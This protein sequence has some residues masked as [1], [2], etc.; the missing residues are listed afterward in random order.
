MQ[1]RVAG[2]ATWTDN[3]TLQPVNRDAAV[4]ATV[5]PGVTINSASGLL[6]GNLDYSLNAIA[7][8]KTQ[9]SSRF[10][11]A[12]S[13]NGVAELIDRRV[14]VDLRASISQQ[15]ASAFGTQTVSPVLANENRREV[16]NLS[17]SPYARGP[18]AGW[19][20]YEAR[21]N[22]SRTQAGGSNLG[23]GN[24]TGGLLRLNGVASGSLN[25]YA[26]ISEQR[27]SFA[28]T[29]GN[30]NGL[31]SVGLTY[32]PDVELQLGT[33]V[34]R[35]RSDFLGGAQRT[36]AS[37]GVNAQ[38]SPT[39][40]TQIAADV[41]RHDY[42]TA[43]NLSFQHR[44]A[45]SVWQ[46]VDATNVTL[47]NSGAP[48]GVRSN[49]DQY[50]LLFASL[51][52]DPIKR[53]VLVRSYLQS[54]GIAPDAAVS[55]GFLSAGPSRLHN[56]QATV[57]LQGPRSSITL[58]LGRTVTSRLGSNGAS[59]GDLALSPQV[60]QRSYSL[61]AGHQLSPTSSLS[62]TASRLASAGLGLG[63]STQL[64]SWALNWNTKLGQRLSAQLG[65]RHSRFES[66]SGYAENAV[67]SSLTQQF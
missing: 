61:S 34:G 49:Y 48:G 46:L 1:T 37:S 3:L 19:A 14:F 64:T 35:E 51:E 45:R 21:V 60:S 23:A 62:V 63:Q 44:F 33:N 26:Q 31:Q 28:G 13:A 32:R 59:S 47:G 27:S 22:A 40:R 5:S 9:Q 54:L 55:T 29:S 6:T 8:F 12:L 42:G 2:L 16:T 50:F 65:A 66:V 38:W 17:V 36:G 52:P 30:R 15:T 53:D 41:Q 18:L 20:T 43:H 11:N 58:L 24:T 67:Y 39:P 25:W 57:T 56:Q 10:Q 7:Y 4:I